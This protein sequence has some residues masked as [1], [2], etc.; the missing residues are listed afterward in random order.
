VITPG[1]VSNIDLAGF[2][3]FY[4]S[5]G[6]GI[7]VIYD[8]GTGSATI[9][10]RDGNDL[11]WDGFTAGDSRKVC[12]KQVFNFAAAPEP[13]DRDGNVIIFASSVENPRPHTLTVEI[14]G[15]DIAGSPFCKPFADNDGHEWDTFGLPL[16]VPHAATSLGL[17]PV[18]EDC[19]A[20]GLN[21]ASITWVCAAF[22]LE[23][24]PETGEGCTPGYWK[25]E[26][27]SCYWDDTPYNPDDNFNSTF[28]VSFHGANVTLVQA[29]WSGGGGYL[30]LGRHAVA[31]LLNASHPDV[32]YCWTV[33]EVLDAVQDAETFD[34]PNLYK[35]LLEDCNEDGCPLNN[36]EGMKGKSR[37]PF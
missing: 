6:A 25:Q 13:T 23:D 1:A 3:G 35:D 27:H 19:G 28:G 32:D 36:C 37:K 5:N 20:T 30:A 26:H 8:D 18:S 34:D 17:L 33:Q 2:D 21:P 9:V 11:A 12:D 29:A 15:S 16:T 14:D 24:I 22:V 10:V 31:A 4:K 7:L